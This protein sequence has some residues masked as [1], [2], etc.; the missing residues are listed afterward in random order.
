MLRLL[1]LVLLCTQAMAHSHGSKPQ[2][3]IAALEDF[4]THYA[5]PSIPRYN[6]MLATMY[7]SAIPAILVVVIPGLRRNKKGSWFLPLLVSFALGGLMGD[8][9]L[10]ILPEVYIEN[11]SADNVYKVM[12][13]INDLV[14]HDMSGSHIMK[15]L[16]SEIENG[17]ETWRETILGGCIFV[18]FLM[19]L[20]IDKALRV[21]NFDNA[22]EPGVHHGH[23]HTHISE[24]VGGTSNSVEPLDNSEHSL[25]NRGGKKLVSE[26]GESEIEYEKE[27]AN[28]TVNKSSSLV[29]SAYLNLISGFVHNLTDGIALASSFY[30]S[31]HVGVTTTIAVLL[32]EIPHELGDFAIL[33]SSGF[34]FPQALK[35]QL[36]T[37]VGAILGTVTGCMINELTILHG[38]SPSSQH[39]QRIPEIGVLDLATSARLGVEP[40][41]LMLPIT[42]GGFIYIAAVGVVPEVLRVTASTRPEEIHKSVW[43]LV[44]LAMGFCLMGIL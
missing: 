29:A 23:G 35:S 31:K 37:F 43:Q 1:T 2:S 17:Q 36:V 16:E 28:K 33:L 39:H 44:C 22:D 19:F 20:L 32:H 25:T 12:R 5:F 18:G 40:S 26:K 7:I 4:L 34:T 9:L 21:I 3:N 8:V 13:I 14:A 27:K 10:H 15:A 24:E 6:A 38:D 11:R 30:N 41:E 42:A